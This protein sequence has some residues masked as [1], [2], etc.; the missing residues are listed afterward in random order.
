MN[1]KEFKKRLTKIYKRKD[2]VLE[3]FIVLRNELMESEVEELELIQT[4]ILHEEQ[5]EVRGLLEDVIKACKSIVSELTDVREDNVNISPILTSTRNQIIDILGWLETNRVS[6]NRI[7][8][9]YMIISFYES[10]YYLIKW[11]VN[12][13]KNI[14]IPVCERGIFCEE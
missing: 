13:G 10:V 2:K 11:V 1:Y 5:F 14:N 7:P 6:E 9:P 12:F 8:F 4:K 3:S